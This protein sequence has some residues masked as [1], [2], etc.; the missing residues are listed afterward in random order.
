VSRDAEPGPIAGSTELSVEAAFSALS[1]GESSIEHAVRLAGVVRQRDTEPAECV[2]LL[3]RA[4]TLDPR[5]ARQ[6]ALEVAN[7]IDERVRAAASGVLASTS[8]SE[9]DLPRLLSLV[10]DE[11]LLAHRATLQAAADA[12]GSPDPEESMMRLLGLVGL[13]AQ[14]HRV[15]FA[16]LV[17]DVRHRT[18]LIRWMNKAWSRAADLR[19]PGRYV[20]AVG[21]LAAVI[22]DQSVLH[23]AT[24]YDVG[25]SDAQLAAIAQGL[26]ERLPAGELISLP[27]VAERLPWLAAY[28]ELDLANASRGGST[29]PMMAVLG[30]RDVSEATRGLAVLVRGWVLLMQP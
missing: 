25:L 10:A 9:D 3:R 29:R 16:T 21:S 19:R 7:H 15:D 1:T 18:Q 12:V 14:R 17:P 27:L 13:P 8:G 26:R 30:K 23:L 5:P 24:G 6:A 20:E 22:V 11:S 4:L 2:A 28:G